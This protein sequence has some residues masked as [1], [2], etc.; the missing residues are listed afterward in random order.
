M[1]WP[2]KTLLHFPMIFPK[3]LRMDNFYYNG[4]LEHITEIIK[5]RLYFGVTADQNTVAIKNT[6]NVYYF[7]I[8]DELLYANYYYDFGPLNIS[9]LYKYCMKLHSF[10]KCAQQ[11]KRI[12]HYTSSDPNRRTNAAFLMGCYAVLYLGMDPKHI[13]SV[14]LHAGGPCRWAKV[15]LTARN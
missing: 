4:E 3:L 13:Y 15:H 8:D 1:Q 10:L 5:N 9:C 6:Q 12:V 11:G 7:S 2:Y 14:F